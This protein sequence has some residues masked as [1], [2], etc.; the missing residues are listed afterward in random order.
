MVGVRGAKPCLELHLVENVKVRKCFCRCMSKR[1]TREMWSRGPGWP[2]V[3][4]SLVNKG[5]A[6]DAVDLSF[7]K[8]FGTVLCNI[9][10]DK[11]MRYR[12]DKW[13]V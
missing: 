1:K 8:A 3:M 10:L 13:T 11:L 2:S 6:V 7:S 4:K 9:L 12:L 5:R